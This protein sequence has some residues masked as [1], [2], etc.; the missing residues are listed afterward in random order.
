VSAFRKLF[1]AAALMATGLGVAALLGDPAAVRQAFD[2]TVQRSQP[3]AVVAEPIKASEAKPTS[4]WIASGVQLLPEPAATSK[5]ASA[6]EAPAL[7]ASLAPFMPANAAPN[8]PKLARTVAVNESPLLPRLDAVVPMAKLRNEAPRPIGNEPR[9]PATIRRTPPVTSEDGLPPS[10]D[11][12]YRASV[13]W[14]APQPM[15]TGF[16][17]D[18]N[19]TLATN[20]AYNAPVGTTDNHQV[21][22]PPWP[23]AEERDEPRTHVIVDGD[24]LE[25]LAGRYLDDPLR[26]KEVFELN[27]E[28]LSAPDLLPIGAELKI[29]ER[30]AYTSW[31]R[32]SRRAGFPSEPAIREAANGNLVP[33][34]PMS[35]YGAFDGPAPRA[36]LA[37]PVAAE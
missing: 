28:L 2:S 6:P 10:N 23:A 1:I 37:R 19:A 20:A 4:S 35:S 12:T 29:P 34:R 15:P 31:D 30:R 25:K 33:I 36:Q 21:S 7:L 9:S 27:R 13:D 3:P 24:S 8:D 26:S 32:Q 16:T 17:N 11:D 14:P 5:S 22:P 18:T